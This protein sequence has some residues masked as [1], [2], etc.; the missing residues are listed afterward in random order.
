MTV[1]ESSSNH[2]STMGDHFFMG[3][4]LEPRRECSLPKLNVGG[5]KFSEN[6][7][8]C[9]MSVRRTKKQELSDWKGCQQFKA[10]ANY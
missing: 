1:S 6:R 5:I 8:P 3:Y 7:N 4:I 9:L 2:D 10:D